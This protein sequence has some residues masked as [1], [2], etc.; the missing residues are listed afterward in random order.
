MPL[1]SGEFGPLRSEQGQASE[2]DKLRV[3]SILKY[4]RTRQGIKRAQILR[5]SKDVK[6]TFLG[7]CER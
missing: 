2:I 5:S 7:H 6:V 4:R 1:E 3:S